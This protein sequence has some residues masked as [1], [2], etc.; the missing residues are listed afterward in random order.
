MP[1]KS[2]LG[3]LRSQLPTGE[4][5]STTYW[6][7]LVQGVRIDAGCYDTLGHYHFITSSNRLVELSDK[8]RTNSVDLYSGTV[9]GGFSK[10]GV[11]ASDTVLLGYDAANSFGFAVATNGN[12]GGSAGRRFSSG[13]FFLNLGNV[14]SDASDNFILCGQGANNYGVIGKWDSSALIWTKG[15]QK[16]TV[17]FPPKDWRI[18]VN[19]AISDGSNVYAVGVSVNTD[20]SNAGSFLMKVDSTGNVIWSRRNSGGSF[21]SFIDNQS[22]IVTAG[23]TQIGNSEGLLYKF[24]TAGT[25]LGVIAI[26]NNVYPNTTTSVQSLNVDNTN[27]ILVGGQYLKLV[28]SPNKLNGY[29]IG[30]DGNLN[31]RFK[32]TISSTLTGTS[33]MSVIGVSQD[34]IANSIYITMSNTN[35]ATFNGIVLKTPYDGS[36]LGNGAYVNGSYTT[37]YEPGNDIFLVTGT[38]STSTNDL[39]AGSVTTATGAVSSTFTANT[40]TI[41][42]TFI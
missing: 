20:G 3:A 17:G 42:K 10:I 34:S 7:D 15:Y 4:A 22:N 21:I 16:P 11:T 29:V 30:L 31:V 12:V 6:I 39:F 5:L 1:I 27:N 9:T 8:N 25:Q 37:T 36:I 19:D 23:D 38:P 2:S 14:T 41:N 24:S 28:G 32:N 40:I 33:I 13:T 18:T 35:L 26:E